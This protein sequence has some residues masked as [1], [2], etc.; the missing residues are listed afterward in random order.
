MKRM[1]T[2]GHLVEDGAEREDVGT[3][4]HLCALRLLRR[5]IGHRADYGAF[6]R[7]RLHCRR[8]RGKLAGRRLRQL[9]HP[10]VK[11]LHQPVVCHHHVC[12]LK[13]PV[14]DSSGMRGR[15]RGRDLG[16]I[17]QRVLELQALPPD[18]LVECLH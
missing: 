5:H 7:L 17:L 6:L 14:N 15:E 8:R 13:I 16:T 9:R 2:C 1:L 18:Q 11:Y 10:K 3:G 12:R 4:I